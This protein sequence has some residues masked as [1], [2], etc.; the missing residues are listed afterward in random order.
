MARKK[1]MDY[2]D[3]DVEGY[4]DVPKR[5]VRKKSPKKNSK[6][7]KSTQRYPQEKIYPNIEGYDPYRSN[8]YASQYQ[9]DDMNNGFN[10]MDNHINNNPSNIRNPRR[11]EPHD[12]RL[13]E[14]RRDRDVD[15]GED[16]RI[17]SSL[18]KSQNPQRNSV[19]GDGYEEQYDEWDDDEYELD[20]E[21]EHH[22]GTVAKVIIGILIAIG[23]F[24]L[25]IFWG[26]WNT[27]FDKNGTAYVVPL[28]LHYERHYLQEA[29]KV[30]QMIMDLD[31]TLAEDTAQ[32]PTNYSEKSTLLTKEMNELKSQT[33]SFSKYVNVP[34]NFQTYHSLL[35][36]FSLKT[37]EFMKNLL[38]NYSSSD[39]EAFRQS[40]LKDYESYFY[41]VKQAR[42]DLES[43]AFGNMS[44]HK[45]ILSEESKDK[46]SKDLDSYN[47]ENNTE[48]SYNQDNSSQIDEYE[49]DNSSSNS[50]NEKSDS[51]SQNTS[52]SQDSNNQNN[53]S[54]N[55]QSNSDSM[56]DGMY[57]SA[58]NNVVNQQIMQDAANS[59]LSN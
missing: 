56:T 55:E 7:K 53:E 5:H 28:E 34:D 50:T 23:A 21:G 14:I 32:L 37:Q 30:L 43:V 10:S 36:N 45:G 20:V 44:S 42:K 17:L 58:T 22:L 51:N 33:T 18:R 13:D 19:Y 8:P 48:N 41:S 16:M 38:N 4:E 11:N 46:T 12:A 6:Q 29:D 40:G 49:V 26:Y 27:D 35:I 54:Q 15:D 1:S 3:W 39:Y 31:K 57:D 59:G 25:F 2:D 9:N 52:N 24:G 47:T